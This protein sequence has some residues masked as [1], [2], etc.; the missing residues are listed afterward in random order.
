MISFGLESTGP[1]NHWDHPCAWLTL[2]LLI[3]PTVV[4]LQLL[5]QEPGQLIAAVIR[6]G[7]EVPELRD[8]SKP[9][10]LIRIEVGDTEHHYRI[11]RLQ[12]GELDRGQS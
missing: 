6:Q 5:G 7:T 11:A 2:R 12:V 9:R 3:S 1:Y 4:Q 8:E 10:S